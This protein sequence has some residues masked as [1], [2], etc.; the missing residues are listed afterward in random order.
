M[1]KRINLTLANFHLEALNSKR[2]VV[3]ED[4]HFNRN[5]LEW[6][7]RWYETHPV[8]KFWNIKSA[9]ELEK[10]I[11]RESKLRLKD[12]LVLGNRSDPLTRLAS[13]TAYTDGEYS[14]YVYSESRS[15]HI[16]INEMTLKEKILE[17]QSGSWQHYNFTMLFHQNSIRVESYIQSD[18]RGTIGSSSYKH[19]VHKTEIPICDKTMPIVEHILSAYERMAYSEAKNEFERIEELKKRDAIKNHLDEQLTKIHF[20]LK[21]GTDLSTQTSDDHVDYRE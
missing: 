6:A 1:S 4:L 14:R 20:N 7:G 13:L 18:F 2:C 16:I 12:K 21:F 11:E 8:F 5:S 10:K 3:D 17:G 19:N 15:H 9:E